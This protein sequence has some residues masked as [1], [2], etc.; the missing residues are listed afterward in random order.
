MTLF[1]NF[2]LMKLKE[3]LKS[4]NYDARFLCDIFIVIAIGSL[5]ALLGRVYLEVILAI[6]NI[7]FQTGEFL[8]L[9]IAM[10]L[11][12]FG[13]TFLAIGLKKWKMTLP[14]SLFSTLLALLFYT[15]QLPEF[16]EYRF[17][18][19]PSQE[20]EENKYEIKEIYRSSQSSLLEGNSK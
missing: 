9:R 7:Y 20:G 2:S 1:K 19:L 3:E 8:L 4:R 6:L 14:L 17:Q 12:I 15:F 11:L 10:G 16:P 13:F 18:K 5:V